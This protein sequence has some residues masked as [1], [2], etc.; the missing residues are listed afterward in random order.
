MAGSTSTST[1]VAPASRTTFAVAGKVY[2]GTITSSPAPI[3]SASTARWSAAVPF[4]TATACSTPHAAATS[5]S[6]SATFG[7]I[8]SAPDSSTSRTASQLR[9][10]ELRER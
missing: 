7:P 5:C 6:S 9:L 1:G 2:A 3:P 4:E 8:V 10:A